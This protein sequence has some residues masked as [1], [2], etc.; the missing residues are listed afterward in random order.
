MQNI[1]P[2]AGGLRL[3]GAPTAGK[4]GIAVL[5]ARASRNLTSF[6][7]KLRSFTPNLKSFTRSLIHENCWPSPE[8]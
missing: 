5:H 4:Q 1:S 3:S 6:T 8:I 7:P 2:V